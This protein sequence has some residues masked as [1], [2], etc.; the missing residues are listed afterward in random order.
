VPGV[1]LDLMAAPPMPASAIGERSQSRLHAN[2]LNRFRIADRDANG[3]LDSKETANDPLFRDLFATFDRDGDGK[4]FEKELLAALDEA[5]AVYEAISTGIVT[6][7]LNEAG[8]GLFGLFDADG[9]GKLSI[10]ELRGLP[11]LVVR[12]DAN[13]DGLLAANEVPRRFE[14]SLTQG[15]GT[16]RSFAPQP[17]R[18]GGPVGQPRPPI[19]PLWFQKMDRNRDGDVS[20]REFLGSAEEFGTLDTDGDGLIGVEEAEAARKK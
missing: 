1:R 14:A 3:Y 19:G 2:Y 18:L 20:R 12:F 6:V 9:D 10:R 8:R 13:A 15:L 11:K 5:Q 7:E 17:V 16:G 4:I